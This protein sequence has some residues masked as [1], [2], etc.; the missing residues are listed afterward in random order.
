MPFQVVQLIGA[1][2]I[3]GDTG[4]QGERGLQGIQGV[5]DTKRG[6]A[7]VDF[8][9]TPTDEVSLNITGLTDMTTSAH[10]SV[11]MQEDDTTSDNTADDHQ[12]VAY[13][14]YC[15]ASGRIAGTGFTINIRCWA[16]YAKGTLKVHYI[17]VV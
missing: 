2:A 1:E 8:G 16:G 3:K 4:P 11:F 17:Y 12:T 9:A 10:I 6:V 15:S 5:P 13:F 7:T 14:S